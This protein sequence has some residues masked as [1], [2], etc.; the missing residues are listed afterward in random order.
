MKGLP[1]GTYS[2]KNLP[3]VFKLQ[4]LKSI[5][6]TDIYLL[7]TSITN[8][9]LTY[10]GIMMFS[11]CSVQ[12]HYLNELFKLSLPSPFSLLFSSFLSHLT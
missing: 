11:T 8:T 9:C 5:H 1:N 7:I 6:K 3:F 4:Y 2:L 12:Q 10:D